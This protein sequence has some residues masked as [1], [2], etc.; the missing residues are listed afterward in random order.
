M[1]VL[2]AY[3]SKYGG[4]KG[5]AERIVQ[6][7]NASGDEAALAPVASVKSVEG[8]DAYVIGSAV[9]MFHWMKEA[10]EFV[11]R[12]AAI[13]AGSPVWLFSSGPLGTDTK[14]AQGRD[15]FQTALPK[16]TAELNE[17]IHPRD[18]KVF[19]GAY[20]HSKL[21][22]SHRMVIAMPAVK[23]LFQEGDFRD[24][25][26]IDAWAGDIALSLQPQPVA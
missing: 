4:T 13:L 9:Y 1:R 25:T 11:Q 17:M 21:S 8:Y 16:E 2:V 24:W 14:D 26:A 3:A 7:L 18:H 12:H 20:D 15:V 5:I 23:K 19:F 10:T 6:K 22:M